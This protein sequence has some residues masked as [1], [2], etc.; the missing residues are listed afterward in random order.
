[1]IEEYINQFILLANGVKLTTLISLIF[2]NLIL[3]IAVSVYTGTFRLKCVADFLAKR[4]L[5]YTL[6]YF[7]I[8][9]IAMVENT[10]IPAITVTWALILAALFG[11]IL[12]NL[13]DMGISIPKVLAGEKD[14]NF[15]P[16][17]GR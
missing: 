15:P 3:G 14:D 10:W 6:G 4:V 1:M 17:P 12:K 11:S 13:K 8:V 9:V 5:P 16:S 2:A 7:A